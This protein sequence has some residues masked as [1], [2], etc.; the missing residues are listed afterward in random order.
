MS[1]ASDPAYRTYPTGALITPA[2]S[3]TIPARLPAVVSKGLVGVGHAV[4][5]F[6]LLHG[7]AAP[8]G[9]IQQL[10]AQLVRHALFAA[11]PSVGNQPANR[12]RGAPVRVHF[13]R[14]LVVGAA[15]A[16]GLYL[17]KRLA[18]LNRFLEELQR[19]VPAALLLQVLHRLIEDALRGRL[20]AAPHHRVDK[21]GDQFGPVNR[22]RRHFPLRNVPFSWHNPQIPQRSKALRSLPKSGSNKPSRNRSSSG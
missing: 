18:V 16:A 3:L 19:I 1:S 13:N 7:R 22:I 8:V 10:V 20:L 15:H 12:Q 6:L 2:Q 17:E 4:H 11:V 9:R 5:V 14:N 21:L